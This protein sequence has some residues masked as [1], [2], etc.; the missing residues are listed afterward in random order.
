MPRGKLRKS[1]RTSK[2]K[3]DEKSKI[4]DC[5]DEQH[6]ELTEGTKIKHRWQA[7]KTVGSASHKQ[8]PV[9]CV[10]SR[11]KSVKQVHIAFLPEKYEPLEEDQD[12][13]IPDI[14]KEETK[15]NL[16]TYKTFRNNVG[17]ALR[18]SWKCLVVGLQSFSTSY[19]GPLSA[20]ATFI[21]EVRR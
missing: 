2:N 8:K 5:V 6:S 9:K 11:E 17:K 4:I 15:K 18:Y 14:G 1:K 20:A 7:Q 19:L 10:P 12:L 3:K 21:P 13:D 16:K